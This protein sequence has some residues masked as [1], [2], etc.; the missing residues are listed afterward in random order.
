MMYARSNGQIIAVDGNV[1]VRSDPRAD[2]L[3]ENEVVKREKTLSRTDRYR[4]ARPR[5]GRF[6]RFIEPQELLQQPFTTHS[7]RE[8]RPAQ[9]KNRA[10]ALIRA[11]KP[12]ES[13]VNQH[14]MRPHPVHS[15]QQMTSNPR[16]IPVID[17]AGGVVVH[18][19]G[20]DRASYR[21][22]KSR[23]T[24][25]TKPADV[26]RAL[27]D[28][29]GARE[30]YVADLDAIRSG[31]DTQ[32]VVAILAG[33][34]CELLVD[35]GG[36]GAPSLGANVREILALESRLV[37]ERYRRHARTPGAIFSIELRNGLL[38]D[39]WQDWGLTSP[40]AATGLVRKAHDI[41]YRAFIILDLARVGT[42][43][44]AGTGELIR[45]IR[46]EFPDVELITG[47]GVK[48]RAD[49]ERLGEAGANAVLVAS[50]LHDGT[51]TPP[52]PAE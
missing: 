36:I 46:E 1:A 52:R 28:A 18:A 11:L 51:L 41:G 24:D 23:L 3:T 37:A 48:T 32:G 40:S 14:A 26:A 38:V 19:V 31:V 43:R 25:S 9:K 13:K 35:Q 39:G 44:G 33:I 42:G 30:L 29:A 20:G 45:S 2:P 16:I 50:A 27:I 12:Q 22:V 8:R 15:R 17:V 49:I 10:P 47:G 4:F 34:D 21:P 6:P 5:E 7:S